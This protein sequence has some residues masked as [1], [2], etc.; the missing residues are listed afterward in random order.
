MLTLVLLVLPV[1]ALAQSS[2]GIEVGAA[3][4]LGSRDLKDTIIL[5]IE[6]L[7]GFLGIAAVVVLLYGGYIWMTAAG[8]EEKVEKTVIIPQKIEKIETPQKSSLEMPIINKQEEKVEPVAVIPDNEIKVIEQEISEQ[9]KD[10]QIETEQLIQVEEHAVEESHAPY[11]QEIQ[12]TITS[13]SA[14]SGDI[15]QDWNLLLDSIESIPS[16]MFFSNLAKPVEISE[17]KIV[18]T[19]HVEAFV[20]QSQ[21]KAKI[22]PLEKGAEKLFG[23]LPRIIIRTPLPEDESLRKESE[24]IIELKVNQEDKK[25]A[26]K[27][28]FEQITQD[29]EIISPKAAPKIKVTNEPIDPLEDEVIEEIDNLNRNISPIN[30]SEQAKIIKDLFQGKVIE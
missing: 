30:L 6:V 4:G 13:N 10:I 26:K 7:L 28:S 8:N 9:N 25:P 12:S 2:L 16:R 15:V 14:L 27:E 23:V 19:F 20:K 3:T 21:E 17:N 22:S 18:I 11:K 29:L 24:N 5:I 1:Q